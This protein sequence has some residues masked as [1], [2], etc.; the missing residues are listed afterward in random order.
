MEAA[1]AEHVWELMI[2]WREP[3]L[4]WK[5]RTSRLAIMSNILRLCS[6][7]LGSAVLLVAQNPNRSP[8]IIKSGETLGVEVFGQRNLTRTVLVDAEGAVTLPLMGK[9]KAADLNL[10]QFAQRIKDALAPYIVNPEVSMYVQK[11]GS[12]ASAKAPN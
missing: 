5:L 6:V 12:A 3:P 1:I 9:V 7:F 10:T 2:C 11:I 4:L 8:Y